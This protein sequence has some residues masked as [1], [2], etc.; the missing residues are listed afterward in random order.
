MLSA[1]KNFNNTLIH[2]IVFGPN[3]DH[4]LLGKRLQDSLAVDLQ[5]IVIK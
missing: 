2:Y 1:F 5:F 3:M 4:F